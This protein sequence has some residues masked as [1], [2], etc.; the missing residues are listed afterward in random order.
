MQSQETEAKRIR[1][2]RIEIGWTQA[3][4][5]KK[6]GLSKT[7]YGR[8]ERGENK[9][10]MKYLRKIAKALG[11]T[12]DYLKPQIQD[13]AKK[14]DDQ[15]KRDVVTFISAGGSKG[16]AAKFVGVHISTII[17]EEEIDGQF[18]NSVKEA[19]ARCYLTSLGKVRNADDW[20]AAAWLLARKWPEEFA[21]LKKH[22]ETGPDG[23]ALTDEQRQRAI[24]ATLRRRFGDRVNALF[25]SE[26]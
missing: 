7:Q 21:E 22:A 23:K 13:R 5:A 9:T 20:K 6:I 8:Y 11:V 14:F 3:K 12:V 10:P 2:R 26:N 1:A 15:K 4:L 25:G 17:R 24:E 16:M 18:A 19:E